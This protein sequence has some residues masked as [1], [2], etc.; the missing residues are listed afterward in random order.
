MK[1]IKIIIGMLIIFVG[2]TTII[3]TNIGSQDIVE[4]EVEFKNSDR[5]STD[6]LTD[7]IGNAMTSDN[8]VEYIVID[9]EENF[10]AGREKIVLLA[11]DDTKW[12]VSRV[13]AFLYDTET[14]ISYYRIEKYIKDIVN[15]EGE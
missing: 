13:P 9:I 5:V 10:N 4:T 14:H 3:N 6:D 15:F 2:V 1:V 8:G 7:I 12:Q 11:P